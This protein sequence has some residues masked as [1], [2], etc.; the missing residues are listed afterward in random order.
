MVRLVF[1]RGSLSNG[2]ESVCD[3]STLHL[4]HPD[5]T[6]DGSATALQHLIWRLLEAGGHQDVIAKQRQTNSSKM[7]ASSPRTKEPRRNTE[8]AELSTVGLQQCLSP[9]IAG[10]CRSFFW[11]R[12][13]TQES[14][15]QQSLLALRTCSPC[16][17]LTTVCVK[18]LRVNYELLQF[19]PF[20]V[21][22]IDGGKSGS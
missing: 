8:E 9:L 16:K 15:Y 21:D 17:S 22:F 12:L 4:V 1:C 6:S 7:K 18:L 19:V 10:N 3:V 2:S 11:T 14:H 20:V 5:V 13:N